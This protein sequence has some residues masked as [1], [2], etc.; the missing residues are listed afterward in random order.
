MSNRKLNGFFAY[1]LLAA[2]F[3]SCHKIHDGNVTDKYVIP[4]HSYRYSTMMYV[5]KVPITTWHTG[6]VGDEYVLEIT[7][8][9]GVDTITEKFSV[10]SLTYECKKVG[11]YFND[12]IPCEVYSPK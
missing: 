6:Y 4:A 5:G 10:S 2:V 12:T 1:V 3:S 7:K 11:N 8:I 9:K